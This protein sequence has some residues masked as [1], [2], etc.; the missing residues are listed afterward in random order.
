MALA[1]GVAAP[2]LDLA[3][4]LD[5]IAAIDSDPLNYAGTAIAVAGV[6]L[7]LYAQIAMGESWRIGV[8]PGETT[9]LVTSGP[10]AW[11][12]NPIFSAM[13]PTALGLAM[14]VPNVVAVAGF[15]GLITAL[16]LQVRAVEEPY[17]LRVHG[18]A[19]ESYAARVGR[20]FP[21]L[22]RIDR[23]TRDAIGE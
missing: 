7:T 2:I 10:F 20:F 22:G 18:S 15:I 19:Y 9:D 14:M 12:R 11:V 16:E 17:L 21:G 1:G 3:G 4:V 23:R 6:L 8:D 13:I 5:P